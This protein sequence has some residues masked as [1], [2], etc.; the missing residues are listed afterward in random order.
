M[1]KHRVDV[2][3]L[4]LGA[5][6]FLTA[7]IYL[8]ADARGWSL[9]IRWIIPVLFIGIGLGGLAGAITNVVSART[10]A[11]ATEPQQLD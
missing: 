5:V 4:S 2:T 11:G 1:R 3:S 8:V 9:D 6:F 10:P 7:A